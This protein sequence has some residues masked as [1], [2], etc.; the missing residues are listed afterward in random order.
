VSSRSLKQATVA[1]PAARINLDDAALLKLILNLPADNLTSA[2]K[3]MSTL[4]DQG[5]SS[6]RTRIR[7]L[8]A[9]YQAEVAAKPVAKAVQKSVARKSRPTP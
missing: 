4:R 3:V 5:F 9:A 8:A 2:F 6:S 1:A 7:R